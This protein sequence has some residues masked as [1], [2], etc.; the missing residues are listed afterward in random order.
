[1]LLCANNCQNN[2]EKTGNFHMLPE[3]TNFKM[4]NNSLCNDSSILV[5]F[6]KVIL[7]Q[8]GVPDCW[9]GQAEK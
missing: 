9:E 8:V 4:K 1:M 5:C 6:K 7:K 3:T 2:Y